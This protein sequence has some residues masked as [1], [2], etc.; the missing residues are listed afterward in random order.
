MKIVIEEHTQP[1]D[2]GTRVFYR[3]RFRRRWFWRYVEH[4]FLD[5]DPEIKEFSCL[6]EAKKV[7]KDLRSG[8]TYPKAGIVELNENGEPL[9][10]IDK[11]RWI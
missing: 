10:P 6:E 4:I 11:C 5:G 8:H 1:A 3:I 7:A 2:D 9:K